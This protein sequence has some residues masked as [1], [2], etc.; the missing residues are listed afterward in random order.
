M[1]PSP[2]STTVIVAATP[3]PTSETS[4]NAPATRIPITVDP[5]RT[6]RKLGSA[7]ARVGAT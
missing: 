3:T 1:L 6:A 2:I 5:S 4:P 7:S